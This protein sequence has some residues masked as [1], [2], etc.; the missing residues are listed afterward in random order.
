M[1]SPRK[2]SHEDASDY[3]DQILVLY[4]MNVGANEKPRHAMQTLIEKLALENE[5]SRTY[6]L[7]TDLSVDICAYTVPGNESVNALLYVDGDAVAPNEGI[8]QT[9]RTRFVDRLMQ[10]LNLKTIVQ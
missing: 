7:G 9:N 2:G 6:R 8:R 5:V 3:I 1:A 10:Q 4:P